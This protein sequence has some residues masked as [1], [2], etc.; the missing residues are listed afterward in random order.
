MFKNLYMLGLCL[1]LGIATAQA[2]DIKSI[3]L[4]QAFKLAEQNAPELLSAKAKLQIIKGEAEEVSAFQN[5]EFDFEIENFGGTGAL[6]GTS[7]AEYTFA[8]SQGIE[9]GGKRGAKKRSAHANLK[10]AQEEYQASRLALE[11]RVTVAYMQAVSSERELALSKEQES[12]A[13]AVLKDVT[14]RV[15]AA[16]VPEIQKKK[17]EVAFATA[18]LKRQEAEREASIKR[19][20]LS[21]Y[22]QSKFLEGSLDKDEF[23]D[24]P[25]PEAFPLYEGQLENSPW[26]SGYRHLEKASTE[27]LRF[28]KAQNIPDPTFKLGMKDIRETGDQAFVAGISFSVPIFNRNKGRI[29]QAKGEVERT[30]QNLAETRLNLNQ[31]LWQ[32]WQFWQQ[33]VQEVKR[34]KMR[35]IPSAEDAFKLARKGYEK[36]RFPYLEVLDAQRTL[37]DARAQYHTSLLRTHIARARVLALTGGLSET[38]ISEFKENSNEHNS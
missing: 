1:S 19:G 11:E 9:I 6:S 29:R 23:Y 28:E 12:L 37:F 2:E 8:I 10:A 7:G 34:L 21:R 36:G 4:S 18:Q 17:A 35:I 22:W 20:E 25:S 13:E 38:N 26:L 32:N 3:T 16:R 27:M 14:K 33:G 30:K 31:D 5:P 15:K 24:V